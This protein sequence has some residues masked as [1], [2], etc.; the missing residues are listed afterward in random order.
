MA[1][2]I[3]F[4]ESIPRLHNMKNEDVDDLFWIKTNI[5][6]PQLS[7]RTKN[8]EFIHSKT[9]EGTKTNQSICSS[10]IQGT[11]AKRS[12]CSS[13]IKG[14]KAKRSIRSST[15]EGTKMKR[16]IHSLTINDLL[17]L[18]DTHLWLLCSYCLSCCGLLHVVAGFTVFARIPDFDS[19]LCWRSCCCFHSCCCLRS[20]CC[21]RS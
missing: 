12:I 5:F 1:S 20:C 4:L 15:I 17:L 16:R 8:N 21:E 19:V 14:T 6:V 3:G 9:I 18:V 13:T 11:K 10:T 2:K 7:K